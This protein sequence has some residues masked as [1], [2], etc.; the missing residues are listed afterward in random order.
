M[1]VEAYAKVNLT[2]EV[3]GERSDGY[4]AL[5]SV[6]MPIS[7]ADTLE[8]EPTA[9]GTIS[10]DTGYADDLC[11]RA[12][13]ALRRGADAG[14]ETR[15]ANLRGARISVTKRIPVGGGLGGG[16]AD[17]AAVITGLNE[18]Y[19]EPLSESE[20]ILLAEKLGADVPFAVFGGTAA[21][22]GKGERLSRISD[23]GERIYLILKPLCGVSTPEAFALYDRL[24]RKKSGDMDALIAALG[25]GD[26]KE[27]AEGVYNALTEA[28]KTLSGGVGEALGFLRGQKGC[29]AAFMTGSGSACVGIFH[30]END[31]KSAQKAAVMR[32]FAVFI[33]KKLRR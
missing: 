28:G 2:L 17:A 6:V 1:K 27:I 18:L 25:K 15:D 24:P 21:A 32:G 10:S 3:F 5:R 4:H 23:N 8:I 13:K 11:V 31:I 16:S 30:D 7:L 20:L 33:A 26:E 14:R 22:F 12:A 29:E 19:G 9:D